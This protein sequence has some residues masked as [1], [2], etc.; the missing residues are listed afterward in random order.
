MCVC[1]CK[2]YYN[3]LAHEIMEANKQNLQIQLSNCSPRR[4]KF[5]PRE[6]L[7]WKNYAPAR[8]WCGVGWDDLVQG[9]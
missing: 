5:K 1:V 2:I 8:R 4:A 6:W 7:L 3:E 9:Q